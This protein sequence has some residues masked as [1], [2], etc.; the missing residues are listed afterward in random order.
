MTRKSRY[1]TVPIM[2]WRSRTAALNMEL[3]TFCVTAGTPF[4]ARNAGRL[5]QPGQVKNGKHQA[6]NRRR[7]VDSRDSI[8]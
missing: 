1:T 4:S 5:F 8:A 3:A 7:R 6:S 2:F